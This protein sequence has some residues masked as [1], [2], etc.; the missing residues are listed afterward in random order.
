MN[1][2]S[3][4]RV[5]DLAAQTFVFS[6]SRGIQDLNLG[7]SSA[8]Q[9]SSDSGL[10]LGGSYLEVMSSGE[11]TIIGDQN[12]N[13]LSNH[14]N[15]SRRPPHTDIPRGI[16]TNGS[17]VATVNQMYPQGINHSVIPASTIN[18]G[19]MDQYQTFRASTMMQ[20]A[21]SSQ[22]IQ[23]FDPTSSFDNGYPLDGDVSY[24][25]DMDTFYDNCRQSFGSGNRNNPGQVLY[26]NH[27]AIQSSTATQYCHTSE[28]CRP[29]HDQG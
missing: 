20:G 16:G 5:V 6:L 4:S 19:A 24:A 15:S 12:I 28:L 1:D 18:S 14:D 8:L 22:Y 7:T 23:T 29:P 25:M 2:V 13:Q 3:L 9:H 21:P 10:L 27:T 26:Q 11:G 17:P